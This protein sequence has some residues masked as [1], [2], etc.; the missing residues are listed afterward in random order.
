MQMTPPA[1]AY[2]NSLVY[3]L[4]HINQDFIEEC[5]ATVKNLIYLAI[6]TGVVIVQ[7]VAMLF[8]SCHME[9][10]MYSILILL[11]IFCYVA[12]QHTVRNNM[13]KEIDLLLNHDQYAFVYENNEKLINDISSVSIGLGK[14]KKIRDFIYTYEIISIIL[15]IIQTVYIFVK[16]FKM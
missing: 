1:A 5:Q 9:Y 14:I 8:L 10:T 16:L 2:S 11:D 4:N 15:I 3:M 13:T 6:M 7:A 12:I